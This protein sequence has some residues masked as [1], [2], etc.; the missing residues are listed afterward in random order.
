MMKTRKTVAKRFLL[1]KRKKLLHRTCGQDH[2]NS[3][4]PGKVTRSK[5]RDP[6]MAHSHARHLM[7]FI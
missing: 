3:R 7:K 2:F 1:T 4:E 5:R 6:A